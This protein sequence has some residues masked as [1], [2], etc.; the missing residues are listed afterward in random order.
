MSLLVILI[1][2]ALEKLAPPLDRLRNLTWFE[3]YSLWLR[4]RFVSHEHWRGTPALLIVVL[5]P[6]LGVAVAQSALNELSVFFSFIF[7]IVILSYCL[8]LKNKLH[9]VHQYLDT[10]ESNDS[11]TAQTLLDKLLQIATHNALPEDEQGRDKALVETILI[12]THDRILGVLFWF[13]ILGPMGAI[14][15]RLTVELMHLQKQQTPDAD[16]ADFNAASL[17]LYHLLAWIPAHL[18]ALS[19]AVTGSFVHAL[20]AWR[21]NHEET[22]EGDIPTDEESAITPNTIP[23]SHQPLESHQP[24]K[25]LQLVKSHQLLTRIGLSALQLDTIPPQ[26]TS[27]IRKTLGL[28]GRSLIAWVTI[29]ALLTLAGWAG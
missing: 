6:T 7:N 10:V 15:Y 22:I 19:Y 23:E 12:V 21:N 18:T 29:L 17:Y 1:S 26:D 14:F 25:S 2:L 9:L 11:E 27:A 13:A 16:N 8:G 4:Q 20:N 3:H 5:I 28:C 24:V